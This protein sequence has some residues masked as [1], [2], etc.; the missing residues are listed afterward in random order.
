M[1]YQC[2]Q[3]DFKWIETLNTF[4]KVREHE[5]IHLQNGKLKTSGIKIK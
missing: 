3:C 5:K 1:K 2:K 4:D